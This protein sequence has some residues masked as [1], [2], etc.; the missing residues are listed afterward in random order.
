[1]WTF[2]K[3]TKVV[4]THGKTN[5]QN[6]ESNTFTFWNGKLGNSNQSSPKILWELD[7]IFFYNK[8]CFKELEN[9]QNSKE[10]SS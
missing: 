4:K 7:H 6:E 1:M 5:K 9:K 3:I 10:W 2:Y 8:T